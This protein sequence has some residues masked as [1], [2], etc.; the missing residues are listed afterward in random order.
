[1]RVTFWDIEAT[2]LDAGFGRLLCCS[3]IDL[4][5]D[6]VETFRIDQAPWRCKGKINDSKLA[7][8]I[9]ERLHASDIV[10]DW[11]GSQFDKR[12]VN[13]RLAK[14]GLPPLRLTKENGTMQ[15]DAMYAS[16][17]MKIGSKRLD[18][19][20]RFF[21]SPNRKT[22]LDPDTWAAASAGDVQ[23]LDEIVVHCE[24]DVRVLKDLWPNIAQHVKKMSFTLSEIYPFITEVPSRRNSVAA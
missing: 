14:H 12:F 17:P 21:N 20:S 22:A 6:Q 1:L 19:I 24:A 15:I 23:A 5:S 8:A 7:A 13:A 4:D 10:V 2:N 11:Y 16:N 3:F 18:N 9:R